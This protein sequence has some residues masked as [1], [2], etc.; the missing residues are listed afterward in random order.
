MNKSKMMVMADTNILVRLL[1]QHDLQ[2][3]MVVSALA[4]VAE[5]NVEV[6]VV[7]KI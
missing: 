5:I 1:N 2:H 4:H 3:G 6:C 7:P